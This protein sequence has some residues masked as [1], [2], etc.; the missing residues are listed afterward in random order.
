MNNT[1][2]IESALIVAFP[3]ATRI[4]TEARPGSNTVLAFITIGGICPALGLCDLQGARWVAGAK[5]V[6]IVNF[7]G[8]LDGSIFASVLFGF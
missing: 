4:E 3:Q 2:K 8:G 1:E 6:E 7:V 5:N